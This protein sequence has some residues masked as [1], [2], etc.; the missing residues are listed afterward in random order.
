MKLDCAWKAG[1]LP[2]SYSRKTE[3]IL[4]QIIKVGKQ[5][6]SFAPSGQSNCDA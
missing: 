4:P 5:D 1:A 6:E 2:L 3:S